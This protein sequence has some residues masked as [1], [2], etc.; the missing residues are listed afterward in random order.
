MNSNRIVLIS[1]FVV[2]II[3][4]YGCNEGLAPPEPNSKTSIS[5]KITYKGGI[6]NWPPVDSVYGIRVV[7]FKNYPPQDII[8]EI[9]S[10][11]AYFT[12][13]S[14]AFYTDSSSF[15]IEI[16]DPPVELQYIVVA[17]QYDSLI[18]SQKAAGVY[19]LTGDVNNP[20]KLNVQ[21]G[22]AYKNIDIN[23][24]FKNLPPQPF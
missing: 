2:L 19:T 23:V 3:Y 15:Y 6:D 9:I 11:N 24:D 17:W 5:G 8:N 13:E 21:K 20:S 12:E 22:N 1:L 16:N 18:T 10:G 14:L 4:F 7:A